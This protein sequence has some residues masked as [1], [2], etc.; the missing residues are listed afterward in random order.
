MQT[1]AVSPSGTQWMIK[2]GDHEAVVVEV[3]GGLRTYRSSGRDVVD[4]Y[5]ESE[6]CPSGAGQVLAPWPNRIRDGRYTFGGQA[7]QL[8]LSEPIHHNAVHGLVRWAPWRATEVSDSSVTLEYRL[9][10]QTGYPWTLQLTTTWTLDGE[11]LRA[12]HT[13]TNLSGRPAPFG[14]G[15]H[16]YLAVPGSVDDVVL[17]V[18]ARSRLLMDGR[19]LPIGAARVAGSEYDFTSPRPIG[20]SPLN[21][22]FGEVPAGGT[23]VELSTVDGGPLVTVWADGAF[24]WWQMYTADTA[25]APRTRRSVAVEPM[26]CP[27]DAFNSGRD[28]ITLEPGQTWQGSWGITPAPG[29]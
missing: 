1:S 23:R 28:V 11:G 17:S 16:P 29:R 26:T 12:D 24:G 14:L 22:A 4:G 2:S 15:A 27:P 25:P 20:A 5:E 9:P 6:L 19:A 18:P 10:A 3:G 7:Q 21:T 13:A 8:A